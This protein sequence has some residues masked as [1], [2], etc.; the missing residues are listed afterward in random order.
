MRG[1]RDMSL[2][3]AAAVAALTMC[4]VPVSLVHVYVMGFIALSYSTCNCASCPLPS[5]DD[6][7][8]NIVVYDPGGF[9]SFA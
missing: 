8:G 1:S 2:S 7:I 3:V 4:A 9:S 6:L 5:W